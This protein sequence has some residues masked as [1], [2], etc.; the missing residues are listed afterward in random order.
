M[1]LNIPQSIIEDSIIQETEKIYLEVGELIEQGHFK[2]ALETIFEYIR[3]ANRYFDEQ[4]PW[5]QV[6][7]NI[8]EC[9]KTLATCVFIIQ[10]LAQLLQPFLPFASDEL[11]R[12]LDIKVNEWK[13]QTN[14]PKEI[15]QPASFIRKNR[16]KSN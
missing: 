10:N 13:V 7:E 4:K 3:S 5:I 16:Y 11:K 14:L 6:K 8:E 9:S 2:Q 15:K 12:M 1:I